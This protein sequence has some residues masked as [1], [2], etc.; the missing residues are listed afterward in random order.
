MTL[1]GMLGQG[2]SNKRH[3]H[4]SDLDG[5]KAL[6]RFNNYKK[7]EVRGCGGGWWAK[8]ESLLGTALCHPG[9]VQLL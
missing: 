5:M 9:P 7:D 2:D 8:P 1:A 3:K 4:G 6:M